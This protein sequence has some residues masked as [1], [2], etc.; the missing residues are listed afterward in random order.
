MHGHPN[1]SG[2]L[3]STTAKCKQDVNSED[4]DK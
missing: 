1:Q 3:T 2:H 4:T